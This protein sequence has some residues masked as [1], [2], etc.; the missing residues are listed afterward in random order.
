MNDLKEEMTRL[1]KDV[2]KIKS[3]M[4]IDIILIFTAALAINTALTMLL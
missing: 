4:T 2:R 3:Q 1:R